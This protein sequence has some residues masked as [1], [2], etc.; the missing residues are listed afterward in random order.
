MFRI[1]IG[2]FVLEFGTRASKARAR[3]HEAFD[4]LWQGGY[5]S[6]NAAYRWLAGELGM[7]QEEC[8]MSRFDE[9]TCRRVVELCLHR[10]WNRSEK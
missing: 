9:V 5:M 6:R 7:T 10:Y 4:P 1:S 3:A 2:P 8:H